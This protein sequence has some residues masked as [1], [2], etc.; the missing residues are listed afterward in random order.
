[1]KLNLKA[2]ELSLDCTRVPPPLPTTIFLRY[3]PKNRDTH[4][5]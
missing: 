3:T 2:A 1:M 4:H 5:Q